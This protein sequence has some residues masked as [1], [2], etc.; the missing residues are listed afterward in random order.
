LRVFSRL[1]ALLFSLIFSLLFPLIHGGIILAQVC[2]E[3]A[4]EIITA[5]IM[6]QGDL[7]I[8]T[9]IRHTPVTCQWY[10]SYEVSIRTSRSNPLKTYPHYAPVMHGDKPTDGLSRCELEAFSEAE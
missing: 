2:T 6:K 9:F 5:N 4:P 3:Y 7:L 1:G 8:Q 10:L